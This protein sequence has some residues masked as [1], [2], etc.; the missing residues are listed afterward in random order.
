[1]VKNLPDAYAEKRAR[2]LRLVSVFASLPE[3][4]KEKSVNKQSYY[5]FGWSCGKEIF[6][7]K[8]GT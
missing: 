4:I 5:N 1:M 3:E 2:L 7:D 6:N 8:K